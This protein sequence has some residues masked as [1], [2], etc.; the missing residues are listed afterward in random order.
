MRFSR[1]KVV[2][3]NPDIT[4]ALRRTSYAIGLYRIGGVAEM[5]Q[6][7]THFEAWHRRFIQMKHSAR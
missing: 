1:T 7:R 4:P 6:A 2:S 3:S 5:A